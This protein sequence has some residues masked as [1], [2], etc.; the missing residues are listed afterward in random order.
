MNNKTTRNRGFSLIE[1]IL[2]SMFIAIVF[3]PLM[4]SLS[5]IQNR[6]LS[7]KSHFYAQLIAQ[8][9]LEIVTNLTQGINPTGT[10]LGPAD[11]LWDLSNAFALSSGGNLQSAVTGVG[12]PKYFAVPNPN[13]PTPPSKPNLQDLMST[14]AYDPIQPEFN[15][16]RYNQRIVAYPVCRNNSTGAI[17]GSERTSCVGG[18][19]PDSNTVEM[20]SEVRWTP[21]GATVQNLKIKTLFTSYNPQYVTTP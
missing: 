5:R 13:A 2:T 15:N 16:I 21:P 1:I 12:T 6:Y 19:S 7:L 4:I 3:I 20:V 8:T 9:N 10:S 11:Y 18:T 14:T 17:S